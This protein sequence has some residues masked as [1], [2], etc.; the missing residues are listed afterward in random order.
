MLQTCRQAH[1]SVCVC[2]SVGRSVC[3]S[4]QKVYCGKTVE[5][6]LMPLG[7]VSGVGREMGEFDGGGDRRRG[8]GRF[9]DE[10]GASHCNQ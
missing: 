10:F 6:I 2:R 4:V 5:W 1:L 7:M 8:R 3:L 9:W